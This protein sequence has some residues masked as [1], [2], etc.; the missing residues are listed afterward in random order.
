MDTETSLK[1]KENVCLMFNREWYCTIRRY[2]SNKK[3]NSERV[4]CNFWIIDISVSE[5]KL[6]HKERG[7]G[8]I[9]NTTRK[10]RV[11]M[12]KMILRKYHQ[13]HNQTK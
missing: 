12:I 13:T 10:G 8:K 3:F 4:K 1:S 9:S 5:I 2:H 11:N 7:K 6:K